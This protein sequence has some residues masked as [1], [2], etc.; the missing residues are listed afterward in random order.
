MQT[1]CVDKMFYSIESVLAMKRLIERRKYCCKLRS[2]VHAF[3]Y[4]YISLMK[5]KMWRHVLVFVINMY[6]FVTQ[7]NFALIWLLQ[8][9]ILRW[10]VVCITYVRLYSLYMIF[11]VPTLYLQCLFYILQNY[12]LLVCYR[13]PAWS[14]MYVQERYD[15]YVR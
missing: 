10:L 13:F 15:A 11:V 12:K 2:V 1:V 3:V 5:D 4:W 7:E 9:Y 14:D 6:R 8:N